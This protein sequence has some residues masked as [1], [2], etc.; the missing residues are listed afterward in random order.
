MSSP[1]SL[2]ASTVTELHSMTI[3]PMEY[4]LILKTWFTPH[5]LQQS[6]ALIQNGKARHLLFFRHSAALICGDGKKVISWY[7]FMYILRK[8]SVLRNEK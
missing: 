6:L 7:V 1:V 2:P 5:M 3:L 8:K 4:N